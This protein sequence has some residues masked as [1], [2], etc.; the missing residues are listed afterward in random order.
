[1][2]TEDILLT[3]GVPLVLMAPLISFLFEQLYIAKITLMIAGV[4]LMVVAVFIQ[5]KTYEKSDKENR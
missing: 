5:I 2:R 4:I 1:M 3:I